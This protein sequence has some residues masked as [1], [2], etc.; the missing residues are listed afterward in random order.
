MGKFISIPR[1]LVP[2]EMQTASCRI[3][4]RVASSISQNDN[5]YA[6]DTSTSEFRVQMID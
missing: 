5:R 2:S 1:V 3:W 6:K 4:T